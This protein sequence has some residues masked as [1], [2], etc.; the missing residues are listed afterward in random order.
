M[1]TKTFDPA[2]PIFCAGCGH[3]GGPGGH[4]GS[5]RCSRDPPVTI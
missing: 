1:T 4:R 2:R 3:F 5:G